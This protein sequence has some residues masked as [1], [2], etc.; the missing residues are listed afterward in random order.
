MVEVLA[1]H[2]LTGLLGAGAQPGEAVMLM[3]EFTQV[4]A[5]CVD[6]TPRA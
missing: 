2:T 5:W 4:F 6:S 1:D 3:G